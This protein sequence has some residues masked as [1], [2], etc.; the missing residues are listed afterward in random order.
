MFLN[1][2]TKTGSKRWYVNHLQTAK[3]LTFLEPNKYN[4][5]VAMGNSITGRRSEFYSY[6]V[7]ATLL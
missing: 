6:Q 4:I 3:R 5:A 1:V 2:K 7:Q